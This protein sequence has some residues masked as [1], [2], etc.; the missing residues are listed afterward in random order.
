MAAN[1]DDMAMLR[2][3]LLGPAASGKTSLVN[4]YV[5]NIC[6]TVYTPT[7][8][9]CIYY[10]T[11]RAEK[12]DRL[13]TVLL[14]IEDTYSAERIDG[15]DHCGKNRNIDLFL[16]MKKGGNQTVASM[17]DGLAPF[18]SVSAPRDGTYDPFAKGRMAFIIL[19]DINSIESLEAAKEIFK[20]LDKR[21]GESKVGTSLE[22]V[23]Y[24]VANK[25]DLD[26]HS[27]EPGRIKRSLQDIQRFQHDPAYDHPWFPK[28]DHPGDPEKR[29]RFTFMDVSAMEFTKVR[30]LFRNIVDDI[31]CRPMLYLNEDEAQNRDQDNR[32]SLFG[33]YG[34]KTPTTQ[35]DGEQGSGGLFSTSFAL[36]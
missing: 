21:H 23:V 11:L 35:A 20:K 6:P 19:F 33:G 32:W 15:K 27:E 25:I 4:A 24:L 5:N 12:D 28:A 10:R 2:I 8:D 36:W 14:E 18:A 31:L 7:D 17:K 13:E 26:P 22:P 29:I 16:G 30:R 9:P 1:D 3:T 34:G